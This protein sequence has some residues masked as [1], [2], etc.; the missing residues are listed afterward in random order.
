MILVGSGKILNDGMLSLEIVYNKD[1]EEEEIKSL[2]FESEP[3]KNCQIL[4]N[5]LLI[6]QKTKITF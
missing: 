5:K 3:V 6:L 4:Y 1:R 2:S